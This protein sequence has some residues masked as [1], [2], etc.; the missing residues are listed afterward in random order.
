MPL[1]DSLIVFGIGLLIGAIG[2]YVGGRVVTGIEDY[3]YAIGTAFIG[4][5]VWAITAFFLGGI[6]GIGPLIV[7]LAWI[8]IINR[9]YPGGWGNAAL[10]GL[11]AWITVLAVLAVLAWAGVGN[12]EAIGVPN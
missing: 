1:I 7:L 11:I 9:R 12:F 2:I 6:P 8:W 10:I 5:I 4:A 3:T